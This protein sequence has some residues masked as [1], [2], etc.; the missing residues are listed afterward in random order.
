MDECT[1]IIFELE[2]FEVD[3]GKNTPHQ[4]YQYE[5]KY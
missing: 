5:F 3:V 4:D 2:K 1:Q